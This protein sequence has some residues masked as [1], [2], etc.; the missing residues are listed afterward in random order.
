MLDLD[1]NGSDNA[2]ESSSNKEYIVT[3]DDFFANEP[4]T[5]KAMVQHKMSH[6]LKVLEQVQVQHKMSHV[7]KVLEQVQ[8][9]VTL[10]IYLFF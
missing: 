10:F 6:V 2:Q 8:N 1:A 9:K 5:S 4:S 3:S 7:L